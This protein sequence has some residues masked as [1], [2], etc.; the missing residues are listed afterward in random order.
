MAAVR[1]GGAAPTNR[2][3]SKT[4]DDDDTLSKFFIPG[5]A[6]I[7]L[8]ALAS[9]GYEIYGKL[10][11][12]AELSAI[13]GLYLVSA[14]QIN[15]VLDETPLPKEV[16]SDNA[17]TAKHWRANSTTSMWSLQN[18]DLHNNDLQ[19]LRLSA[20]TVVEGKGIRIKYDVLPPEQPVSF[21]VS[22]GVTATSAFADY[23]K[24][25]LEEQI[26][27]KMTKRAFSKTNIYPAFL[28]LAAAMPQIAKDN[29]SALD[30]E[31]AGR[32]GSRNR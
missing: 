12:E 29:I 14:E 31:N 15:K 24:A 4:P 25:G 32:T 27:S 7:A 22:L 1:V 23:Y 18:R 13:N 26:Q 11:S 10:P 6:V 5:F 21:N 28:K 3:P 2:A 20:T 17:A 16:F 30:D 9:I 8:V 19:Y